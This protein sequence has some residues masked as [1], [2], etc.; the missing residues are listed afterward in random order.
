[1]KKNIVAL[2]ILVASLSTYA[3]GYINFANTSG[4][5]NVS[6]NAALNIFGQSTGNSG[7]GLTTGSSSAPSAY[8]YALLFQ[9][10]SGSGPTV[11]ASFSS[12]LSSGWLFSGAYATNV[13]GAGRLG[14]GAT[15]VASQ[16]SAGVA[17]QFVTIGWS[18]NLG[19]WTSVSNSIQTGVWSTPGYVGLSGVGTGIG[20][21]SQSSE[22]IF[23]GSTGIQSPFSLFATPVPEP[24]TLAL[25]ALGGASLLLFRRRK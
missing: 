10:Y 14:G 16:M 18:A 5:Q 11:A 6:T 19:N 20:G 4:S 1:M 2:S 15:A 8:I 3:Q 24:G 13:L 17:N 25:A 21:T 12:L 7:S 23:G 22:I 9:S